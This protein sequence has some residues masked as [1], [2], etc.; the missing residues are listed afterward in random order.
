MV[1]EKLLVSREVRVATMAFTSA[2]YSSAQT[3]VTTL[4]ATTKWNGGGLSNPVRAIKNLMELSLMM[5]T[6]MALDLKTWNA[7]CEN[8]AVQKYVFAKAGVVP[9]PKKTQY[10]EWAGLLELPRPNIMTART[11]V[12]TAYPFIWANHVALF[13]RPPGDGISPIDASTFKTF[14]W[15]SA[16][17][18]SLPTEFGGQVVGGFTVRSFYNPFKGAKGVR[19]IIVSHDDAEIVTGGIGQVS[20]LGGL[21][22]N[23][24][25]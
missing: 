11:K 25:T 2:N 1:M 5:P 4:D 7:F 15:N 20:L 12:L 19:T 10:D 18:S 22:L 6:D 9:L 13:R 17:A 24:F 16:G 23:A 21:I 3:L 14:R 8:A